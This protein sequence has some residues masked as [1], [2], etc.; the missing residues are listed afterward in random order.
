MSPYYNWLVDNPVLG[1]HML[2]DVRASTRQPY[3]K[4]LIFALLAVYLWLFKVA[5]EEGLVD[6]WIVLQ[7]VT[8][9]LVSIPMSHA[10]MAIEFE[11]A[12]WEALVLTRLSAG[13][14]VFGKLASRF[15][16]LGILF[17][18]FVPVMLVA[19]WKDRQPM[20]FIV[21]RA[22]LVI[23]GWGAFLVAMTLWLSYRLRR[24]MA[25][26][27]TGFVLQIGLV[28]ILPALWLSFLG[29]FIPSGFQKSPA[30]WEWLSDGVL[31]PLYYNPAFVLGQ[32]LEGSW[33]G[34]SP[35]NNP[36]VF[37]GVLQGLLYI[38]AA[39]LILAHL[40]YA[41]A[42]ETRKSVT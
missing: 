13:Q 38:A 41:V 34:I 15:I 27:A 14:I 33:G 40:L 19:F 8:V 22:E 26:A 24:G 16:M 18:V 12:T 30:G 23:L 32:L 42:R 37:W 11:K 21:M 6:M 4:V 35:Q 1:Y 10:T 20:L 3:R 17:G 5:A 25:A 28:G 9:C 39:A 36:P 29:L 2:A 7:M 31:A